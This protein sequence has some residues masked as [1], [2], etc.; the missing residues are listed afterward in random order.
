MS[1]PEHFQAMKQGF[2]L[3]QAIAEADRCLLCHDPPCSKGCPAETDPGTFI[4]KLRLHNVTG[5]IRTI[6]SNNIL[7]GACG[8]LCP[9]PRLCEKECS[10]T[11]IGRP[12][13]IGKI[14]RALVEHGWKI[15]FRPFRDAVEERRPGS[16]WSARVRRAFPARPSSRRT[17]FAVT[18]FE[19]RAEPGGVIRYGV[20]AYRFDAAF[21]DNEM[22]DLERL[23]V[24]SSAT[25]ASTEPTGAK[26][27]LK[28][29]FKAVFLGAGLWAAER[30]P[31]GEKR[32]GR[33]HLRGVPGHAPRGTVRRLV[34]KRRGQGGRRHRRRQRRHGLRGVGAQSSA[35][36]TRTSSTAGPLPR[37]PRR[38]RSASLRCASA[39]ISSC[40]TSPSG[41]WRTPTGRLTGVKLVRTRLGEPDDSGRRRPAGDQGVGVDAGR[42]A[43]GGGHRQ[44]AGRRGLV[45]HGEDGSATG[46]SSRTGRPGRPRPRSCSPA[47]TSR[48]AP[49]WWSRRCRTASSRPGPSARRWRREEEKWR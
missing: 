3:A 48:A 10:A 21:L 5:A 12:V 15:G 31:G 17:G 40:S 25:P 28:D 26:K 6:K 49:R 13:E 29:G 32:E 11:G 38:R 43:R 47:G 9:T 44:Q 1:N 2:D 16:R 30:I 24:S 41:T 8:V 37:C 34:P 7:G 35:R 19:E 45:G 46:W 42:P 20:P 22:A 36:G 14:Q 18:V 33:P 27:L 23:G 39:C 4:R